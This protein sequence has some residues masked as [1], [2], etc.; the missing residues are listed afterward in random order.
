MSDGGRLNSERGVAT[1][2]AGEATNTG[3]F[4]RI[5]ETSFT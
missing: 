4:T 1:S 3:R 2:K 5:V